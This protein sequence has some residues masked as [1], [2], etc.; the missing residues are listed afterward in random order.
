M[1]DYISRQAAIKAFS[2]KYDECA[3]IVEII[4]TLDNQPSADVVE[5]VRC[6]DCRHAIKDKVL[7]DRYDCQILDIYVRPN[8]Y[9][10]EGERHE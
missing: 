1:T 6:K 10:N 2:S 8:D 5:V 7:I 3:D 4:E 9:C